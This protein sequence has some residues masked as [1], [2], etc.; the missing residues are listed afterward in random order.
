MKKYIRTK[1]AVCFLYCL[2]IGA[3]PVAVAQQSAPPR[4]EKVRI[5]LPGSQKE[6]ETARSR[7]GAWAPVYIKL[8]A[9]PAGNVRDRYK[10]RVETTDTENT[11][12]H[13]DVD[14]PALA[15][16]DDY[17]AIA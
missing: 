13:Y 7:N 8:K 3:P 17:N 5:G 4:I 1:G 14:V 15:P 6:E 12:Y 11:T 16:N 10:L 2:L 9:S